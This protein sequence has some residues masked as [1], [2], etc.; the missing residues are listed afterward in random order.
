[1]ANKFRDLYEMIF[2]KETMPLLCGTNF[3]EKKMHDK[4]VCTYY[5]ISDRMILTQQMNHTN[6]G[7]NESLAMIFFRL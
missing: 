6:M 7:V 3:D 2:V 4:F 1:M 5:H